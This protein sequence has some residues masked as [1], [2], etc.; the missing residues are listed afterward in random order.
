MAAD[1][2]PSEITANGIRYLVAAVGD[3]DDGW[4]WSVESLPT[5]YEGCDGM[6]TYGCGADPWYLLKSG[7]AWDYDEALQ[8]AHDE[9]EQ[10][11]AEAAPDN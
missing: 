7:L 1:T 10:L 8:A 5:N 11:I 9:R 2:P 3:D 6:C 4:D